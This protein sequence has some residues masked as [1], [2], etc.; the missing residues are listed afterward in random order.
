VCFLISENA[1]TI[2]GAVLE[3]GVL[4]GSLPGAR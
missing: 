4:P 1:S 3:V 2:S